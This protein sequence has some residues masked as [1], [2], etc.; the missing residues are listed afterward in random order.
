MRF[1]VRPRR[2]WGARRPAAP[3]TR[4]PW[5]NGVRVVVH[6][7][8]DHGPARN[9]I[10]EECAHLRAMQYFHQRV[11]GWNDIGYNY[12]IMPSGRVYEGRGFGV[13]GAHVAG[14]NTDSCG[15]SFAGTYTDRQ[16]SAAAVRAFRNLLARLEAKGARVTDVVPHRALGSTACPGD[17]VI[18]AL[19][20]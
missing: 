15:I 16:P 9:R 12:I 5:H 11:R 14:H 20:L 8:A 19:K 4:D 3:V 6:H 13:R 10:Y 2:V 18:E 1:F 7:T 17:G